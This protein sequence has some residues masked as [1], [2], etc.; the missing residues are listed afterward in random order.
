[1]IINTRRTTDNFRPT[2]FLI[3]FDFEKSVFEFL[4]L[5]TI[6]LDFK[7]VHCNLE[8]VAEFRNSR[9]VPPDLG[10]VSAEIKVMNIQRDLGFYSL[11]C[12]CGPNSLFDR[13]GKEGLVPHPLVQL[14]KHR[15]IASFS[16]RIDNR[17]SF[18]QVNFSANVPQDTHKTLDFH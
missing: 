4:Q 18:I 16:N 5:D 17:S 2:T 15:A 7:L 11:H 8:T 9:F 12:A 14:N 13:I 10:F 6:F 3:Y 1:M